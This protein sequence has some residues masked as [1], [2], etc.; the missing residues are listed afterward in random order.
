MEGKQ[1]FFEKKDQKTFVPDACINLPGLTGQG[2]VAETANGAKVFC[3][4]FSKKKA[5]LALSLAASATRH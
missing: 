3:F 1:S 5:L 2:E 4:F